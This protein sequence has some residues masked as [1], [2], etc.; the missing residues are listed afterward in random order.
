MFLMDAT[1]HALAMN[2]ITITNMTATIAI[3]K[4]IKNTPSVMTTM[5]ML[6]IT[7][8]MMVPFIMITMIMLIVMTTMI[9]PIIMIT[10]TTDINMITRTTDTNMITRIIIMIKEKACTPI[11]TIQ[12]LKVIYPWHIVDPNRVSFYLMGR[13]H[14]STSIVTLTTIWKESSCMSWQTPWE[15]LELL[16]LPS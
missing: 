10:M 7:P 14:R 6:M 2:T 15:V 1:N 5:T 12:N 9:V 11:L 16:Y 8:P 13:N 4:I 3:L